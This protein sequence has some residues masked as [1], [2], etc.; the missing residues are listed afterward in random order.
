MGVCGM[1][2]SAQDRVP[3]QAVVNTVIEIHFGLGS[4]DF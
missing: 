1:V 2:P 3:W 4:A